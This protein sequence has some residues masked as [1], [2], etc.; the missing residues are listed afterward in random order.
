ME[1]AHG[2]DEGEEGEEECDE[3]E[4]TEEQF[5]ARCTRAKDMFKEDVLIKYKNKGDSPFKHLFRSKGFVW[6]SNYPNNFFEW[7][8]AGIQ[9][10]VEGA[11]PW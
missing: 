10:F 2:E 4:E 1:H 6:L 7:S 5:E 3:E 8:H 9:L 11:V